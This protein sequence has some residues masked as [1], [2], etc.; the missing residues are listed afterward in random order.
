M[1]NENQQQQSPSNGGGL[2]LMTVFIVVLALHVLVIGGV[3]AYSLLKGNSEPVAQEEK[4]TETPAEATPATTETPAVDAT[5][6][7]MADANA[8]ANVAAPE[9]VAPVEPVI[10]PVQNPVA[11]APASPVA[12]VTEAA[13][14]PATSSLGSYTV[15]KGDTLS[16]IARTHGMKVAELK[17]LNG[18][19]SDN[20]KI[21]QELKIKGGTSMAAT[22][23]V[24]SVKSVASVSAPAKSHSSADYVVGKGDTLT[25]IAKQFN[26]TASAIMAAN[27]IADATKLKIG[28]KLSI[29]TQ[30]RQQAMEQAAPAST[31]EK[32]PAASADFAMA[33]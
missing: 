12:T 2:K 9:A 11:E 5:A 28:M 7:V 26:T 33:K 32:T 21:G 24:P 1:E 18:M 30:V 20:L 31:L 14:A 3:S 16:K 29:P 4:K 27:K 13:P 10:S 8:A 22:S 15:A 19:K 25:K 6:P 17:A 23:S